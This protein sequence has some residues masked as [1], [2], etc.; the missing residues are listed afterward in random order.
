MESNKINIE[1]KDCDDC[2]WF[3][4][5]IFSQ[6]EIKCYYCFNNIYYGFNFSCG[7]CR[8]RTNELPT[9]K[10]IICTY[11]DNHYN[12][13]ILLIKKI[14]N[15]C[16]LGYCELSTWIPEK[17]E[18]LLN[19]IC[20]KDTLNSYDPMEEFYQDDSD[21]DKITLCDVCYVK[22][23]NLRH[24]PAFLCQSCIKSMPK[25]YCESERKN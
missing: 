2:R 16:N 15:D 11:C 22:I 8:Q 10:F 24:N 4:K 14:F 5:E 25:I 18:S 6:Q 23:N 7:D 17:I 13:K 1:K 21:I 19:A 3:L 20:S 12:Y 9:N